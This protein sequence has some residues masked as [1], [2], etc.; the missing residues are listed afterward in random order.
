[1]VEAPAVGAVT[2]KS[3]PTF[4]ATQITTLLMAANNSVAGKLATLH[5]RHIFDWDSVYS[6]Q[7]ISLVKSSTA[8]G[9]AVYFSMS[10]V[11]ANTTTSQSEALMVPSQTLRWC[12]QWGC[13]LGSKAV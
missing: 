10:T 8:A 13:F 9:S 5:A 7:S 12:L 3:F 2:T 4:N 6:S 1:V 11:M